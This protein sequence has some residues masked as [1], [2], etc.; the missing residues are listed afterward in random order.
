MGKCAY[1]GEMICTMC[2]VEHRAGKCP[3]AP[4]TGASADA[5]GNAASNGLMSSCLEN[6][7]KVTSAIETIAYYSPFFK[8]EFYD[9]E[10]KA[11]DYRPRVSSPADLRAIVD[12]LNQD[13]L[14][15]AMVAVS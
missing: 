15:L 5:G 13:D 9:N 8:G 4:G 12:S 1:C 7:G 3:K 10:G 14:D 11:N 6:K 2:L